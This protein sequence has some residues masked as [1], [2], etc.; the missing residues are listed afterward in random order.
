MKYK[1]CQ[2]ENKLLWYSRADFKPIEPKIYVVEG[3]VL[4]VNLN[5]KLI[6]NSL[7]IALA[8]RGGTR[9]NQTEPLFQYNIEKYTAKQKESLPLSVGSQTYFPPR[10]LFV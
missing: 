9:W 7:K 3:R 1:L 2:G 8:K 4:A 5:L 10:P 6:T